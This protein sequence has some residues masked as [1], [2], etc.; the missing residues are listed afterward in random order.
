MARYSPKTPRNAFPDGGASFPYE[1]AKGVLRAAVPGRRTVLNLLRTAMQPM[2]TTLYIY[3]G[4]WN[5]QDTGADV[6]AVRRSP[7]R[8]GA[9]SFSRKTPPTTT[10]AFSTP[11][12]AA[13]D[14]TARDTSA[15]RSAP[16]CTA[17]PKTRVTSAPRPKWRACS[18]ARGLGTLLRSPT[19]FLPGDV[20]SMSGHVWLCVGAC[21]DGSLV[22]AHSSPTPDRTGTGR[23]GGVQLSAI[24]A[25]DSR[26]RCEAFDLARHY[27]RRFP[28]WSARYAGPSKTPAPSIPSSPITPTAACFASPPSPTRKT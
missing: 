4:G 10:A 11:G 18:A 19:D 6:A 2:G 5:E 1:T 22:I 25:C 3:G 15:G 21:R 7:L 28:T 17:N 12:F 14:S 27:M 24:P 9:L 16:R 26:P 13:A 23:G 8:R 20:F